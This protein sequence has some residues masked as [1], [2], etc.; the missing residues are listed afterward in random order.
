MRRKTIGIPQADDGGEFVERG[1]DSG[2]VGARGAGVPGL[3]RGGIPCRPKRRAV[4]PRKGQGHNPL[5]SLAG[6]TTATPGP[7]RPGRSPAAIPETS[8]LGQDRVPAHFGFIGYAADK[9]RSTGFFRAPLCRSPRGKG[10][11]PQPASCARS[12]LFSP[13]ACREPVGCYIAVDGLCFCGGASTVWSSN[14]DASVKSRIRDFASCK[15]NDI[16]AHF[17]R[18]FEILTFYRCINVEF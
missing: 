10:V 4:G 18:F 14:L 5:R 16:S 8:S 3:F 11:P 15:F 17:L 12:P 9:R 13:P 1:G 2:L 6:E 7:A